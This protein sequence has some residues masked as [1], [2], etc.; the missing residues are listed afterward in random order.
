M[1]SNL[2]L[3]RKFLNQRQEVMQVLAVAVAQVGWPGSASRYSKWNRKQLPDC[4]WSWL[5]HITFGKSKD[6]RPG[7]CPKIHECIDNPSVNSCVVAAGCDIL[8]IPYFQLPG[9]FLWET[10]HLSWCTP[11]GEARYF[12]H[13]MEL[14]SN[15]P[16]ERRVLRICCCPVQ[17]GW[18]W[19][20]ISLLGNMSLHCSKA[21]GFQCRLVPL[22]LC[23]TAG[24]RAPPLAS[25]S[26]QWQAGEERGGENSSLW[27]KLSPPGLRSEETEP[28]LPSLT[29]ILFYYKKSPY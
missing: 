21:K 9:L 29:I 15:R 10:C 8:H 7:F 27:L 13:C 25:V 18:Q 17:V 5:N 23:S 28:A 4:R 6:C 19:R 16:Q 2:Y 11:E 1:G 24:A 12:Q 20:S 26:A 22:P 3:D 14:F